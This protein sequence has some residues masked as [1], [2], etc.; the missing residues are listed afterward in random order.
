[1]P[2]SGWFFMHFNFDR[3]LS[4]PELSRHFVTPHSNPLNKKKKFPWKFLFSLT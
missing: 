2:G 1:M 4:Y 3:I